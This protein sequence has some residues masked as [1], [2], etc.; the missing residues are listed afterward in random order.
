M[1]AFFKLVADFFAD[2]EQTTVTVAPKAKMTWEQRKKAADAAINRALLKE[3][4]GTNPA[5]KINIAGKLRK[6]LAESYTKHSE[7]MFSMVERSIFT[8]ERF[9][10]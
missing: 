5:T 7:A 1:N 3:H 10:H 9:G 6:Q 4:A 2:E 8:F